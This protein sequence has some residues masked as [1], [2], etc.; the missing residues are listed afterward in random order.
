MHAQIV[1]EKTQNLLFI[2]RRRVTGW[3]T[4]QSRMDCSIQGLWMEDR[5]ER[6]RTLQHRVNYGLKNDKKQSTDSCGSSLERCL[7]G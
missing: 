5:N 1:K 6:A 4:L 2:S 3:L 7:A